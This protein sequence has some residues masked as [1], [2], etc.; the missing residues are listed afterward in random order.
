[1]GKAPGSLGTRS[2]W[3]TAPRSGRT[4][5]PSRRIPT[6]GASERGC[7]HTPSQPTPGVV[8]LRARQPAPHA[9]NRTHDCI[10]YTHTRTRPHTSNLVQLLPGERVA[11]VAQRPEAGGQRAGRNGQL[12]GR[13]AGG[14]GSTRGGAPLGMCAPSGGAPSTSSHLCPCWLGVCTGSPQAVQAPGGPPCAALKVHRRGGSARRAGHRQQAASSMPPQRPHPK[15]T[16]NG[17]SARAWLRRMRSI[18]PSKRCTSTCIAGASRGARQGRATWLAAAVPA[19]AAAAARPAALQPH[20]SHASA[21]TATQQQQPSAA[22]AA[23]AAP[24]ALGPCP[25]ASA[26]TRWPG[27]PAAAT[28][29]EQGSERGGRR[30]RWG[31]VPAA[32]TRR[33]QPNPHQRCRTFRHDTRVPGMQWHTC[34]RGKVRGRGRLTGGRRWTC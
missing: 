31:P 9:A 27:G 14:G 7:K 15:S 5:L 11:H 28:G 3:G 17:R 16:A 12:R 18:K 8:Q 20:Y 32:G 25:V 29:C 1:M 4:A 24:A 10:H 34:E 26:R 6:T 30:G 22:G 13:P 2:A 19:A 21:V 33:R 23:G